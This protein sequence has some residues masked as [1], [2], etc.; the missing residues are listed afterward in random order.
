MV[1]T[2]FPLK[3]ELKHPYK[4]IYIYTSEIIIYQFCCLQHLLEVDSRSKTWIPVV[5]FE[6][7]TIHENFNRSC[8]HLTFKKKIT[9]HLKVLNEWWGIFAFFILLWIPVRMR[10][11]CEC[12]LA[13]RCA[14]FSDLWIFLNCSMQEKCLIFIWLHLIC[15]L[16][17]K[18]F[19][20][21]GNNHPSL[22]TNDMINVVCEMS[23]TGRLA[24]LV[25]CIFSWTLRKKQGS[26]FSGRSKRWSFYGH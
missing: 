24:S 20:K 2:C 18:A 19:S 11:Y 26:R 12:F 3:N 16:T 14:F 4:H 17:V 23:G 6:R 25:I 10:I 9:K 8:K 13:S 21:P 5:I 22:A 7:Q 1:T 15:W